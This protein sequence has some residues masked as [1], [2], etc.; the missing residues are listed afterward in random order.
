MTDYSRRAQPLAIEARRSVE[1]SVPSSVQQHL[2]SS[3]SRGAGYDKPTHDATDASVPAYATSRRDAVRD[4]SS[5][6]ADDGADATAA[7]HSRRDLG[8]SQILVN[9]LSSSDRGS[10]TGISYTP[11]GGASY[12]TS[13]ATRSIRGSEGLNLPAGVERVDLNLAGGIDTSHFERRPASYSSSH[14]PLEYH[15]PNTSYKPCPTSYTRP[16]PSR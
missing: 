5:F 16:M 1:D 9:N 13:A 14:D 4:V 7:A 8:G 2:T 3:H 12:T 10:P 6:S 15:R 11:S